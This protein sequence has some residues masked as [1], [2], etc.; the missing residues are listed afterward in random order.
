MITKRDTAGLFGYLSLT[1]PSV[2]QMASV[3]F[4]RVGCQPTI[5]L[6]AQSSVPLLSPHVADASWSLLH[7][8]N[9][10]S[11]SAGHLAR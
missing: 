1:V 6:R 5:H 3:G 11:D 9:A 4:V 2:P 10:A 7:T 8:L